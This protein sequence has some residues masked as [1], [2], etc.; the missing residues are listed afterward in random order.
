MN[1]VEEKLTKSNLKAKLI[2]Q[3]HDELV[4]D[5]PKDE[6]NLV[7]KILTSEM[8]GAFKLKVPL[9]VNISVAYRWGEAH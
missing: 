7:K 3:V 8:E 4:V 1:A 5:C 6:V 2:M 9:K